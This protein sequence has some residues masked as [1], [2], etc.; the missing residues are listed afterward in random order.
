MHN[1]VSNVGIFDL[2]A[3]VVH[4]LALTCCNSDKIISDYAN[5]VRK[6]LYFTGIDSNMAPLCRIKK[7]NILS[8]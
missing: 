1:I 4:M 3:C 2:F 5:Q 6:L 7:E 8:A